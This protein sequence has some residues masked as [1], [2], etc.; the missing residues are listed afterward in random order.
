MIGK[1]FDSICDTSRFKFF[2]KGLKG[3]SFSTSDTYLWAYTI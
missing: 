3:L 2:E 1:G